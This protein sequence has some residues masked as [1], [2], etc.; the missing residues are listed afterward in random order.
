MT[1]SLVPLSAADQRTRQATQRPVFALAYLQAATNNSFPSSSRVLYHNAGIALAYR[2]LE[3]EYWNQCVTSGVTGNA[4]CHWAGGGGNTAA[5]GFAGLVMWIGYHQDLVR[6]LIAAEHF[7]GDELF[8]QRAEEVM[9]QYLMAT[10]FNGIDLTFGRFNYGWNTGAS[11]I[12]PYSGVPGVNLC[13]WQPGLAW[14]DSDAPRALWMG[15]VL[16]AVHLSSCGAPLSGA[17]SILSQW[18]Q[19]VLDSGTQSAT[20]SCIQYDQDGSDPMNCGSY[21]QKVCK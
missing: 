2:H 14:D 1:Q 12:Q 4:V 15:D 6:L 13:F 16:R 7:T 3:V 11:P 10:T 18:V 19:L 21:H 17:Y 5:A 20:T 9:D 8:G